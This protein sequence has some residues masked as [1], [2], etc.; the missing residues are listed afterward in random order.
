LVREAFELAGEPKK[1]VEI[2]CGHFD[3]YNKEPWHEQAAGE[4]EQWFVKYLC[5]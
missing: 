3:V 2:P 5:S 1:L 4:A